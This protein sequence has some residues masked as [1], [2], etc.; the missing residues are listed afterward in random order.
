MKWNRL[1]RSKNG[2]RIADGIIKVNYAYQH[3]FLFNN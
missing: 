2:K 1:F 3:I